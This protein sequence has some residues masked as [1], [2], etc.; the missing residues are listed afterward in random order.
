MKRLA[1]AKSGVIRVNLW[2][3]RPEVHTGFCI[4]TEFIKGKRE[5]KW[6]AKKKRCRRPVGRRGGKRKTSDS[7]T[8]MA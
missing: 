4:G 5:T 8:F 2:R 3:I 6:K 1:R 7:S